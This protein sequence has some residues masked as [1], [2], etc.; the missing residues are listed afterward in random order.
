MVVKKK[1]RDKGRNLVMYEHGK[2]NVSFTPLVSLYMVL[3]K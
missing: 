3:T 2:K 1:K